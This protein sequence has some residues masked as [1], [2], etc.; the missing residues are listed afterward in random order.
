MSSP[1][2]DRFDDLPILA[3]LRQRLE[4]RFTPAHGGAH[5]RVRAGVRVLPMGLAAATAVAVAVVALVALGHRHSASRPARPAAHRAHP[6][7]PPG[8]HQPGAA[9]PSRLQ[10]RQINAAQRQVIARDPACRQK[11]NRGATFT[12]AS[13][14]HEL[15][16]LL[17]VMRRPSLPPDAS[18]RTLMNGGF[19]IGA[20]VFVDY[21]RRARSEYGK[22]YYLVPEARIT[23]FSPLP[24]RCSG[25]ILA[26]LGN[27]LAN[28]SAGQRRATLR[29]ESQALA[30]QRQETQHQE[31][32]CFAIVSHRHKPGP[33]GV[34]MGCQQ[35][36]S[37]LAHGGGIDII[38]GD[39][40]HG[41]IMA[42]AVSDEVASVTVEFAAGGGDPARSITVRPVNNVIV[43]KV[44]P[45]THHIAFPT[46][47]ALRTAAGKV[48]PQPAVGTQVVAG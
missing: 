18:T 3:E 36:F 19:D 7:S 34:D 12:H 41:R 31:G 42:G 39:R 47:V 9:F 26:A 15:L 4:R 29:G 48:I 32:L 24:A 35:G 23:P 37:Q 38:E 44:P 43:V 10:Q 16:S 17:G 8:P 46:T 2:G 30:V 45:R 13:P 27:A 5:G 14:G 33:N 1:E 40:A 22:S 25:E 11:V 6:A 28:V 21:I 20:G